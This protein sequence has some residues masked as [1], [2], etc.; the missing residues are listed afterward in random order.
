MI[1]RARAG[2]SSGLGGAGAG[3]LGAGVVGSGA[4]VLGTE[5]GVLGAGVRDELTLGIYIY[6]GRGGK[7]GPVIFDNGLAL[8]GAAL[9]C[10]RAARRPRYHRHRGI[11]V[12]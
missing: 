3:V 12:P 4:G 1:V 9:T 6:Y 11:E 7:P 5:A 10:P 8:Q 2:V